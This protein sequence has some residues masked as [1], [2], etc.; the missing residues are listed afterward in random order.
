VLLAL[1]F[2][3]AGS[4]ATVPAPSRVE[5][6]EFVVT[7]Q[8][9]SAGGLSVVIA[10]KAGFHLYD[11][12]PL[13]FQVDPVDGVEFPKPKVTRDDGI[14][15][16]ACVAD[17]HFQCGARLS[18]PFRSKAALKHP[19]GGTMAFAECN[20]DLCLIEKVQVSV[21]SK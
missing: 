5:Q 13:N 16:T 19:V 20:A 8:L 9:G 7:A 12:Y 10:T 1:S 18:V 3:L 14:I 11:D 17:T 21:P 4:V 2:V 6:P 15:E